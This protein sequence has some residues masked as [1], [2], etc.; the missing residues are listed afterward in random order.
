MQIKISTSLNKPLQVSKEKLTLEKSLKTE[1]YFQPSAC[2]KRKE[3]KRKNKRALLRE[4]EM[5]V[6]A[7]MNI[8]PAPSSV[9]SVYIIDL[10][11]LIEIMCKDK[12]KTFCDL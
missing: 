2:C 6:L 7:S 8:P 3:K 5:D 12:N 9:K 1:R 4:L 10:P 11:K